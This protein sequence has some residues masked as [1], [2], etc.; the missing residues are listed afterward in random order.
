MSPSLEYLCTIPHPKEPTSSITL[1][2]EY[3]V[4]IYDD[5]D[6]CEE[7]PHWQYRTCILEPVEKRTTPLGF[8][9]RARNI[10]C[11]SLVGAECPVPVERTKL[12]TPAILPPRETAANAAPS[13]LSGLRG[14]ASR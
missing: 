2:Y 8:E 1:L 9:M 11:Y 4:Y 3:F 5:G 13:I 14:H 10:L 7:A 6:L 12:E